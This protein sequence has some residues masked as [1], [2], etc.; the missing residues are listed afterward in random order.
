MAKRNEF[1]PTTDLDADGY[2]P[3]QLAEYFE[4]NTDVYFVDEN[5]TERLKADEVCVYDRLSDLRGAYIIYAERGVGKTHLLSLLG[6]QIQKNGGVHIAIDPESPGS[7]LR[8]FPVLRSKYEKAPY[9]LLYKH[10]LLEALDKV[11]SSVLSVGARQVG[12]LV[13]ESLENLSWTVSFTVGG[14]TVEQRKEK[15]QI[16]RIKS[17]ERETSQIQSRVEKKLRLLNSR[18]SKQRGNKIFERNLPEYKSVYLIIDKLDQF[19]RN[20]APN[21]EE[22][23]FRQDILQSLVSLVEAVKY[24]NTRAKKDEL[25]LK[26]VLSLRAITYLKTVKPYLNNIEQFDNLIVPLSWTH[27]AIERILLK[28]IVFEKNMPQAKNRYEVLNQI[29]PDQIHYLGKELPT[30]K[31]LMALAE[32]RPRRLIAIWQKIVTFHFQGKEAVPFSVILN[33]AQIVRGVKEYSINNVINEIS[34]EHELD[35]PE[36]RRLLDYLKINHKRISRF[37]TKSFLLEEMDIFIRENG[38]TVNFWQQESP[39]SILQILFEIRAI[40]IAKKEITPAIN[41]MSKDDVIF[42]NDD[43]NLQVRNHEQFIVNPLLWDSITDIEDEII[44][45]REHLNGHY[46]DLENLLPYLDTQINSLSED[47]SIDVEQFEYNFAKF[48]V[49]SQAILESY[50]YPEPEDWA[51]WKLVCGYIE[52]SWEHFASSLLSPNTNKDYAI[53]VVSERATLAQQYMLNRNSTS[54]LKY[55]PIEEYPSLEKSQEYANAFERIQKHPKNNAYKTASSLK[56]FRDILTAGRNKASLQGVLQMSPASA[57]KE[58][59]NA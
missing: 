42:S 53:N 50:T 10:I 36:V 48:F 30:L 59:K 47:G 33:E 56:S 26:V 35:Y 27:S 11:L 43:M 12:N 20:P 25:N 23:Q 40:G 18:R 2:S 52:K 19:E 24:F 46:S 45:R 16:N 49:I 3:S 9:E 15:V 32:N 38:D 8:Q 44:D 39:E 14:I 57:F 5:G 54:A 6:S 13:V 37:P 21:A 17:L 1:T 41:W 34:A 31:F 58:V 29:F 22:K 7:V 55:T 28:R 51:K 4:P